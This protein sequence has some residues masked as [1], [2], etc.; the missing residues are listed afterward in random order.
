M[1]GRDSYLLLRLRFLSKSL[2][3]AAQ[4]LGGISEMI[5]AVFESPQPSIAGIANDAARTVPFLVMV[6][7][8]FC[9]DAGNAVFPTAR[10]SP[11][12]T[13]RRRAYL[14]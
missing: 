12:I 10:A 9:G 8:S 13:V 3:I 7:Y 1:S 5:H 6:N 4:V 2:L 14:L 11:Q